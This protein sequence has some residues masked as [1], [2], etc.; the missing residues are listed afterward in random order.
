MITFCFIKSSKSNISI[1]DAS[2]GHRQSFGSS[3]PDPGQFH[4]L[5]GIAVDCDEKQLL[6]TDSYNNHVQKYKMDGSFIAEVQKHGT[7]L[8]SP[9]FNEPYGIAIHP[10]NRNIDLCN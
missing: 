3:G 6:V 5:N 10:K 9:K 4:I 7:M 2:F 8:E 1:F